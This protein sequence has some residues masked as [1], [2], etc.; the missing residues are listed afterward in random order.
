M[1]AAHIRRRSPRLLL[2][3]DPD[4]LLLAEPASLH[5]PSPLSDGLYT[6]L[7]EFSGLTSRLM[8]EQEPKRARVGKPLAWLERDGAASPL[9][10][11]AARRRRGCAMHNR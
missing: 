1:L 11:A 3:Q 9:M 4:N 7:E 2:P 10:S 8:K 6:F 5:R